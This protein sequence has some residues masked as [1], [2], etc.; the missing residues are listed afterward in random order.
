M[1]LLFYPQSV[2]MFSSSDLTWWNSSLKRSW[3][4]LPLGQRRTKLTLVTFKKNKL[5]IISFPTS[6]E[7]ELGL[8]V[9]TNLH[10]KVQSGSQG[11]QEEE[12]LHN[13]KPHC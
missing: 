3:N 12:T 6:R 4:S 7:I 2:E 9:E 10:P 5:N 13:I 8:V 11:L 1:Y